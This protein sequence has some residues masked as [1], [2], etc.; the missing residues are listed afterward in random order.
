MPRHFTPR[1]STRNTVCHERAADVAPALLPLFLI[2]R[3]RATR[4]YAAYGIATLL[5]LD[6]VDAATIAFD[7]AAAA[8]KMLSAPCL[9]PLIYADRCRYAVI[10]HN[11]TRH[12]ISSRCCRRCAYYFAAVGPSSYH[13]HGMKLSR[14]M[15][16]QYASRHIKTHVTALL[17]L[18][19]Q[20]AIRHQAYTAWHTLLRRFAAAADAAPCCCTIVA[21]DT[22]YRSYQF[23]PGT[24][25]FT[26]SLRC[27]CRYAIITI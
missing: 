26:L 22:I 3:F 17:P 1:H 16:P 10:I 23:L 6:Y 11:T 27:C 14:L 18:C 13:S 20:R 25:C 12:H 7:D 24:L 19:W 15:M 21:A 9:A 2:Q 5:P 4:R 8:T